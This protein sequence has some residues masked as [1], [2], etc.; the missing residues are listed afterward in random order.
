MKVKRQKKVGRILS[1]FK[2]NYGHHPP[3]QVLLDGTFCQACLKMKVNIKE[4]LPKYLGEVKLLT[5]KCCIQECEKL[6]P[7]L[8]GATTILKQFALHQCGHDEPKSA[9]TCL[10][11]MVKA[12]KNNHYFLATNDQFLREKCRKVVGTPLMY[13]HHCAPVLEKPSGMSE[14]H[15][16]QT[17]DD[18][19]TGDQKR[20]ENLKKQLGIVQT[21][22]KAKKKRKSG[23]PNPLSCLKSKKKPLMQQ[24][25]N[26]E[27]NS[28]STLID[29]QRG[30]GARICI[31]QIHYAKNVTL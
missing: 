13:L 26:S 2:H 12:S 7:Q 6:G 28:H 29:H 24:L 15:A 23:N 21:E 3:Y 4:Q 25:N 14:N 11:S 27:F 16:K 20:V 30:G 8:S 10:Q 19:M 9:R 31:G 1:F 5:T 22:V 17:V 18:R